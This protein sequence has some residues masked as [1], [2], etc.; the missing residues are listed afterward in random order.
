IATIA[1]ELREQLISRIKV[2]S[3]MDTTERRMPQD[4]RAKL[5]VA[6]EDVNFR[7]AVIPSLYGE[8]AAFRVLRQNS[9]NLEL[10]KLG[11]D[12]R[13]LAVFRKGIDAPN[14]MVLITGPTGS[15][16]TTT[17]YSALSQLNSPTVKIATVEDPIE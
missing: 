11:M 2:F 3:N 15:G 13:Q 16:K 1:P 10:E 5:K 17:V 8:S 4:G 12:S 7:V 14:G 6:G 9:L